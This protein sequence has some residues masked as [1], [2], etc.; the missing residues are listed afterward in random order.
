MVLCLVRVDELVHERLDPLPK[1]PCLLGKLED[2]TL[3]SHKGR[4]ADSGTASWA[5]QS[6]QVL[7]PV[8]SVVVMGRNALHKSM[9]LAAKNVVDGDVQVIQDVTQVLFAAVQVGLN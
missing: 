8:E 9:S 3:S 2:H 5:S 6:P 1:L 7:G 4:R